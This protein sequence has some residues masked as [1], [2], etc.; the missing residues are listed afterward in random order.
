MALQIAIDASR[1]TKRQPTGTEYYAIRLIQALIT[2]NEL[3]AEPF[4]FSLYFRDSPPVDLFGKSPQVREVV[5]PFPRLWTHFR[6][7]W[8]LWRARPDITFSP[9][10]TLP[11]LFPGRS[12]VTVH[13]LGY[14]HYPRAHGTLQRAYLDLTTR[15]SAARAA[16]VLADSEATAQDLRHFYGTNTEK[17]RVVYPGVD[18]DSFASAS[19]ESETVRAKYQLPARYFTY[20]GTLQPRKNI[21]RLI[22]AFRH[23]QIAHPDTDT[24]LVLAGAKSPLFDETWLVSAENVR[25]IGYIDE[26]D[27]GGLLAG[28]IALVFPSLYEGFGFPVLEAMHCG[29]PVIAS[30]SSSLPE[31]VGDAG[32]LVDPERVADIASAM[33]RCSDDATLRQSLINRSRARARRFTW[34]KAAENVMNAFDEVARR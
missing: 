29:T 23:W 7:A 2:A 17:I 14:K 20:I 21:K 19:R 24:V 13:D 10:H 6:W 12:V 32:L 28:A 16:L 25:V 18:G 4:Q 3:R 11:F 8:A 9:A 27:K 34:G 15:Y 30:N 5:I 1:A 33:S 22:Q 31:L 26:A